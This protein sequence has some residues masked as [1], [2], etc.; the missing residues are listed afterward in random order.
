MKFDE[1]LED[2]RLYLYSHLN[3]DYDL[4]GA[5]GAGLDFIEN[6]EDDKTLFCSELI[7]LA[8]K[9][10]KILPVEMKA[11]EVTP[12]ELCQYKLYSG[13]KQLF[14][15]KQEIEGFNSIAV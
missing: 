1:N 10:F 4:M 13:I 14:G 12:I 6:Q 2:F 15:D 7:V 3:K 11:S 9:K 8:F 5:I